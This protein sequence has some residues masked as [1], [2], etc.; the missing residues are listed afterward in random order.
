MRSG[1]VAPPANARFVSLRRCDVIVAVVLLLLGFAALR[2]FTRL[3]DASPWRNMADFPD[4]YCA[5]RALGHGDSPYTY[6]P[7]HTCEHEINSGG[8]FRSAF[9]AANPALAVPAPLPAYDFPP[10]VVLARLPPERAAVLDATAILVAVLLSALALCRLG[11]PLSLVV[12]ALALSTAYMEL[13]A[14]QVVPFALL[15]LA[16]A[17]L[18]LARRQYHLAGV[19]SVFTAIEPV[20]GLPVV[21]AT[22]LFVPR[23][24]WSVAVCATLFAALAFRLVGTTTLLQ[25]L[26][27]VLPAQSV[28]EV[29]FPFQYSLTYLLARVGV[30]SGMAAFGGAIS[31][32]FMVAFSLA[33]APAV[34]RRFARPELMVFIP[35]LG[36]IVGGT[37]LHPEELCFAIP[38]LLVLATVT[39]GTTRTVLALALC[40]VAI[41]WILVWGTKQLFLASIFVCFVI[42]FRLRVD[43]R[44][45]IMSLC[46]VAATIYVFELHPPS[47]PVVQAALQPYAPNAL[48]QEEWRYYAAQRTSSDPLWLAI[49]VPAW[50]ALIAGLVVAAN[51]QRSLRID[52]LIRRRPGFEVRL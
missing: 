9:F 29:H 21:L 3:G 42:L 44:V 1:C 48:V 49:K 23:A 28:S 25:Y 12:A 51:A 32:I 7:L 11:I 4:F 27:A 38:A 41:P 13:N 24:R 22:V 33:L 40:A 39:H 37:Y 17:G 19:L 50:A 10:F 16:L 15:A 18:A 45:A 31:Y 2:D 36:S 34:S 30:P 14:G 20:I 43:L 26:T 8:A 46:A 47:L 5:G 35:A 52:R 6:E